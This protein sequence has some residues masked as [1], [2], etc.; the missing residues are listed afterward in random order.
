[1]ENSS[2]PDVGEE[3]I[4]KLKEINLRLDKILE[5]ANEEKELSASHIPGE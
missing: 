1:M 2:I 4:S 5:H 3:I